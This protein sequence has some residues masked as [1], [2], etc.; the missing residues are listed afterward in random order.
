MPEHH[1]QMLLQASWENPSS[2][3]E[4]KHLAEYREH[5]NYPDGL[6]FNVRHALNIAPRFRQPLTAPAWSAQL[7]CLSNERLFFPSRASEPPFDPA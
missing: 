4:P 3:L 7:Q 1:L 2:E 5:P 6:A